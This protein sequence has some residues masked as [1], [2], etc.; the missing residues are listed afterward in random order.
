MLPATQSIL[1]AG[2]FFMIVSSTF[3]LEQAIAYLAKNIWPWLA[4]AALALVSVGIEYALPLPFYLV[5]AIE[6]L[7]WASWCVGVAR[8]VLNG[9]PHLFA[10][11]QGEFPLLFKHHGFFLRVA[12]FQGC[13][14]TRHLV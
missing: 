6:S 9:G 7:V 4:I 2:S 14:R 3:F 13:W 12:F 11:G 10:N 8:V 5:Y 1:V